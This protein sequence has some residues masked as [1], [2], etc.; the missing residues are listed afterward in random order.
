MIK[1]SEA[2]IRPG[3]VQI[4]GPVFYIRVNLGG[5]LGSGSR[6]K[7][8]RHDYAQLLTKTDVA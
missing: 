4:G 7:E 8:S 2:G 1:N 3:I 5:D 6:F